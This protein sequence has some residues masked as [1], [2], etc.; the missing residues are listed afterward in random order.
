MQCWFQLVHKHNST[1]QEHFFLFFLFIFA[2]LL[3]PVVS[4]SGVDIGKGERLAAQSKPK[5]AAQ[6]RA[7]FGSS[8]HQECF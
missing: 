4:H 3:K 6:R 5:R 7:W 8:D 1:R 2:C